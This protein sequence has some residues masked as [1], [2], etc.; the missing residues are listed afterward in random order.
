MYYHITTTLL[1][2]LS[3]HFYIIHVN[4]VHFPKADPRFKL[5]GRMVGELR[6]SG[7]LGVQSRPVGRPSKTLT[8]LS[9]LIS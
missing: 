1:S 3:L 8:L 7:D 5:M 9:L 6:V 2:V 4:S